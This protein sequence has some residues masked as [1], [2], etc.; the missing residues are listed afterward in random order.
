MLVAF[1]QGERAPRR[2]DH[3]N[4][5]AQSDYFRARLVEVCPIDR[6]REKSV[7]RAMTLAPL[8][9]PA[10]KT[11]SMTSD[12]F[13]A[14]MPGNLDRWLLARNTD[15]V[16]VRRHIHMHPELSHHEFETAAYVAKLLATAGLQPTLVQRG[17]GVICDIGEGD[18][19]VALRADMDALPLM[20]VKN[21]AYR[22]TVD[23]VTHACGHDVH[24]TVLLGVGMALAQ[25]EAQGELPGRVRLIFQPA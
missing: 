15:L 5:I 14:A 24:T 7:R 3:K 23:G 22:S 8:A 12:P 9:P 6:D 1:Y 18:R 25:L 11:S 19:V 4:V 10:V 2:S 21:V 13:T 17:N 20:D 16:A